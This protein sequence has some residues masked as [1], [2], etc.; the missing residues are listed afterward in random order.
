MTPEMW[1]CVGILAFA[2]LFFVTE[3]L[4]VDVVALIV[5]LSLMITDLLSPQEA[6]AGFSNPVVLTLAALFVIGGG[7]QQ[8]GLAAAIGSQVLKIAGNHP[9][10]LM[11]AVILTV[12]LLSAFM[13]DAGTVAVLLPAVVSLA[14]V[15]RISPSKLLIPL[16]IGSLLGGA[17]TLIGTP[18]NLIASDTLRQGG[19]E[20]FSFFDYTPIGLVLILT[21]V[22]FMVVVGYRLLPDRAPV[23][24]VQRVGMPEDLSSRYQLPDNLFRLRVR[25]S[26]TLVG[27]TLAEGAFGRDFQVNII[28]LRRQTEARPLFRLG[29]SSLVWQASNVRSMKPSTE[30]TFQPEDV[31][32]VQGE[33]DQVSHLAAHWNLGVQPADAQDEQSLIN[34]EVGLAEVLLPEDSHLIGKS[35]VDLHFGSTY[36]LTVLGIRRPGQEDE[37]S[38][39]ETKLRFG[40]TLLVQG[41]W[42]N[43]QELRKNQRDFVVMGQ[44][45]RM[46]FVFNRAKAPLAFLILLGMLVAM[47]GEVVPLTTASMAGALLMV[48]TGCVTIDQAY[49]FIDWKS[50]VLMAGMLPMSTALSKVGLIDVAAQQ[51]T[52]SLGV[53]GPI[54]VLAGLFLS[55]SLFT[56]VLSNTATTVLLAPLA[57]AAAQN[58]SVQ[59]HAFLMGVAIAASMALASPVAS[60]VN[61]LV[62]GAGNYRFID[63]LKIGGPMILI[64]TV[65]TVLLLPLLWP[66]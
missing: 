56:Q 61:T 20:P 21:G 66:F 45:D 50:I 23:Q 17:A 3:W 53:Y 26:S 27:K 54:V 59:P 38:L 49:G 9:L 12:A 14:A 1:I 6:I 25:Q 57:L 10:R 28:E 35:L 51:L 62:M 40:D 22:I 32:I 55:T 13:S 18:P 11:V 24:P 63:Y 8:T 58:L 29:E 5:V 30:T 52:S 7:I 44:P 39:K 43:I 42:K 16:S 19:Y 60:P 15:A 33:P 4:R 36:H 2:I 65:I 47:V 48:L 37:L 31:I 34:Q 41:E 64:M 46:P